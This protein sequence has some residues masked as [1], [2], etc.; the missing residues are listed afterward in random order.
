MI[1]FVSSISFFTL[2]LILTLRVLNKIAFLFL[3]E[4]KPSDKV[5]EEIT[6]ENMVKKNK[7]KRTDIPESI[8]EKVS[9][10]IGQTIHYPCPVMIKDSFVFSWGDKKVKNGKTVDCRHINFHWYFYNFDDFNIPF[11]K[12]VIEKHYGDPVWD[13]KDMHYNYDITKKEYYVSLHEIENF[14]KKVENE[15]LCIDLKEQPFSVKNG[16]TSYFNNK[17][18]GHL[19]ANI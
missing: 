18:H 12:V 15:I 19:F 5:H 7:Y 4:P 1:V 14:W 2:S 10:I 11:F 17:Q 3:R 6:L 9:S 8:M 13:G 16:N